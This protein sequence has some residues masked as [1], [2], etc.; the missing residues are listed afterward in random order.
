VT[1]SSNRAAL[2]LLVLVNLPPL[3]GVLAFHWD[4]AALVVLYWSKNLVIGLY[5]ILK[6]AAPYRRIVVLHAVIIAGGFAVM[7]LGQPLLLL[8]VLVALKT[9]IDVVLHL[10]EREQAATS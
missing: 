10:R 4:V 5:N 2:V 3:A 6:M 9:A 7:A 8:M 1:A